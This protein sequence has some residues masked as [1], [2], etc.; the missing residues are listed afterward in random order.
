MVV[1]ACGSITSNHS[2]KKSRDIKA[3]VK[4]FK[5][6]LHFD[7]AGANEIEILEYLKSQRDFNEKGYVVQLLDYFSY[8]GQMLLAYEKLTCNLHHILVKNSG[9]GLPL[10]I[11]TKCSRHILSGLNFLTTHKVVHGDVKM[12]NIMWNANS[13]RFQLVDFGLSFLLENQPYQSFQ[14][15]GYRSP[16]GHLWNSLL[17]SGCADP[18]ISGCCCASD[19]WSFAYVLWYL[20][21][22]NP[23][24]RLETDKQVCETCSM[25]EDTH[26]MHFKSL[27]SELP[28]DE[29]KIIVLQHELF[30][31]LIKRMIK[32]RTKD[33]IS[34]SAALQH[35]FLAIADVPSRLSDMMLLPTTTLLLENI[36]PENDCMEHLKEM[37]AKFGVV[38]G[39][40]RGCDEKVLVEYRE[41]DNCSQAHRALTG[42]VLND[43][44]IITSYFPTGK[45][46]IPGFFSPVPPGYDSESTDDEFRKR[47]R[48]DSFRDSYGKCLK[49]G[50]AERSLG[51]EFPGDNIALANN[52]LPEV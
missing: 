9:K 37:C 12:S 11:I 41:A 3:A 46:T 33:R 43:R 13:G 40:T 25:A 15:S 42:W 27:Q 17:D 32:C 45:T 16:E 48:R 31:D 5:Q 26:C 51:S 14:S 52:R 49:Q 34:P 21:A 10:F 35:S 19:M 18:R 4:I 30:L 39:L 47:S 7:V 22:G 50:G 23:A 6:G 36:D 28:Q 1:E 29:R 8:K 38:R 2:Q 44:T 24:S 20:Y